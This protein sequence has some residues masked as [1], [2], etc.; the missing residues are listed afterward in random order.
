MIDVIIKYKTELLRALFQTFDMLIWASI[1]SLIFGIFFG[2]LLFLTSE[3]NIFENKIVYSTISITA[4]I[5][6]AVPFILFIIVIIP[7][8]RFLIG[9]G[10]GP[11]A[12]KIPLTIIGIANL[13]KLVELA[14]LATDKNLYETS[15][16]LGANK[17]NYVKD[18]LIKES[19][20]GLVASFKTN[21]VSILAYSTVVGTIGGGGLGY[22]AINEGFTNFN[23]KLMWVIIFIMIILVVIIDG[24]LNILIKKLDKR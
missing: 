2:L 16:H 6:R 12:S 20:Q 10:F 9:T 22:L 15:Y 18:F 24:S 21:V 4:N 19:R 11:N 17:Y 5:I 3:N 14:F 23:Y 8:N 7:F 1:I 13:S